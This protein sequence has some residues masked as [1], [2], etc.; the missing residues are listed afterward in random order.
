MTNVLGRRAAC[1]LFVIGAFLCA[2]FATGAPSFSLSAYVWWAVPSAMALI[3]YAALGGF[4]RHRA[5][6]TS[7]YRVR[8]SLVSLRSAAPWLIVA[9][10]ALALESI[11]LALG[12]H[13]ASVPTLSTTIDHV[14]VTHE[15]RFALFAIW[16]AV[17]ANP[18]RRLFPLRRAHA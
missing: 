16:L 10:G 11:G 8:S 15:G 12:G 18:L 9:V 14:L 6:V 1:S 17:G 2:W 7:Y 3:L 13:S 4:S 5:E